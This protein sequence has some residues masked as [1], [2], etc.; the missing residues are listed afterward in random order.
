MMTRDLQRIQRKDETREVFDE[1]QVKAFLLEKQFASI[2]TLADYFDRVLEAGMVLDIYNHT[3]RF[4]YTEWLRRREAG[5]ILEGRVLNGRV[6]Y[7]P[8]KD[9]PPFLTAVPPRP[10]SDF[11]KK[12]PDVSREG[13]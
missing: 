11:E 10:L 3:A 6:R 12:V 4:D 9:V 8:A 5:E 1:N 2:E 13:D 7:I